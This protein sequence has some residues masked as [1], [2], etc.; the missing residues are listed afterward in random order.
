MYGNEQTNY[1]TT[2]N[3]CNTARGTCSGVLFDLVLW[4]KGLEVPT[5]GDRKATRQD[6]LDTEDGA[7][8]GSWHQHVSKLMDKRLFLV[9]TTLMSVFGGIDEDLDPASRGVD[10][11]V[12]EAADHPPMG[13]IGIHEAL[14]AGNTHSFTLK[15]AH[16]LTEKPVNDGV[17]ASW[18]FCQVFLGG[19]FHRG[20]VSWTH[21]IHPSPPTQP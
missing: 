16:A 9:V 21:S 7:L 3:N 5:L 6:A 13:I 1:T 12:H 17:A 11:G 15:N 2:L 18:W 8:G 10:V 20:G 4:D 14:F 19:S